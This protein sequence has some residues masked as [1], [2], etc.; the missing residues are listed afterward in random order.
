MTDMVD[1]DGKPRI[2][3]NNDKVDMGAYELD[4]VLW[5]SVFTI[6]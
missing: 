4:Y 1:L 3:Q 6:R 2:W 5:G